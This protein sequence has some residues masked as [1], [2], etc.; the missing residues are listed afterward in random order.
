MGLPFEGVDALEEQQDDSSFI[1][2]DVIE[3]RSLFCHYDID[4]TLHHQ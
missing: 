2:D 1:A 4:P 3:N